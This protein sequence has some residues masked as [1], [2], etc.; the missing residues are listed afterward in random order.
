V[1]DQDGGEAV[2]DIVGAVVGSSSGQVI[3]SYPAT[4]AIIPANTSVVFLWHGF[5]GAAAYLL[6]VWM[7]K[8]SGKTTLTVTSRVSLSTLVVGHTSYT[9]DDKGFLP[10]TYQYDLMPLDRY[11]NALAGK[12]GPI[13]FTVVSSS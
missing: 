1:R 6:H 7:V 2:M 3:P 13:Q 9:W 11:G 10:G 4:N 5:P 8:Q 12:S